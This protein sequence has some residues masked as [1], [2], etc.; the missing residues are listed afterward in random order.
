MR[1][2]CPLRFNNRVFNFC[3]N[4]KKNTSFFILVPLKESSLILQI[5]ETGAGEPLSSCSVSF[6]LHFSSSYGVASAVLALSFPSFLPSR[7]CFTLSSPFLVAAAVIRVVTHCFCFRSCNR[8]SNTRPHN[9]ASF[10]EIFFSLRR[11]CHFYSLPLVGS[12]VHYSR[13]L[14]ICLQTGMKIRWLSPYITL[15]I[16]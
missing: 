8:R 4:G 12:S 13:S 14:H 3:S 6:L 15:C 11:G 2:A 1:Q 7:L 9:Q 10:V 5:S 16:E